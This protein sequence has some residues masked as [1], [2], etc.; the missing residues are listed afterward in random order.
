[1][2]GDHGAL[3]AYSCSVMAPFWRPRKGACANHGI[4]ASPGNRPDMMR[5][6]IHSHPLPWPRPAAYLRGTKARACTVPITRR[7]IPLFGK[8][9]HHHPLPVAPRRLRQPESPRYSGP[10]DCHA[11]R[12]ATGSRQAFRCLQSHVGAK[13]R[14]CGRIVVGSY[15]ST[16]GM[17]LLR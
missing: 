4:K 2:V 10:G 1:V 15:L 6:R 13:R 12:P 7:E 11:R 9:R 8:C 17:V 14:V 5:T 3:T 16:R